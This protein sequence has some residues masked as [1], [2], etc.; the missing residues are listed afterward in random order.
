MQPAT[1]GSQHPPRRYMQPLFGEGEAAVAGSKSVLDM[2]RRANI[3]R[4][5]FWMT[6]SHSPRVTGSDEQEVAASRMA[7]RQRPSGYTPVP[8]APSM[9]ETLTSADDCHPARRLLNHSCSVANMRSVPVDGP[10]GAPRRLLLLTTRH[11]AL[12]E[13]CLLD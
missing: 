3:G 12:G 13:E 5:S 11:I 10:P 8:A 9:F 4:C 6:P 1:Q 2:R 7:S